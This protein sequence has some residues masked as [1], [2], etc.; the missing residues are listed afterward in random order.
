MRLFLSAGEVSGDVHGSGLARALGE[1]LPGVELVG[2]GSS[3]MAAAGVRILEDLVPL[4]AVGLTENLAVL[5]PASRALARAR[6][7][8]SSQRPDAV[9]LIDYQGANMQLAR[10][11]R[12][13]GIPSFYYISPQEW[14]WGLKGGPRRVARSVD[15]ILAVFEREA[16]VY[17]QAGGDVRFVGHPLLDQ[18]PDP[19]RVQ[20]LRR[21]LGFAASDMVLGLFPGSRDP[22][23]RSL[24]EPMIEAAELA[25]LR[26]PALRIVLPVASS[27][28]ADRIA[29]TVGQRSYIHRIE[30]ASGM[31]VLALCT[32]ALAASG[33]ITLE[34]AICG[35]PVVAAYR[36][37]AITALLARRLLK[38]PYVTLPNIVAA[39]GI[40][41]ELLQGEASPLAMAAA[42]E[43]L[44]REGPP[45]QSQLEGLAAV[46]A[47]LGES[48]AAERAA[49]AIAQ[50]LES[51]GAPGRHGR[52]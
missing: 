31:E 2:W 38:I 29:A 33:T 8:L 28:F 15:T 48:G 27:H 32:A 16:E 25:R 42:I 41:P 37:S 20:D 30:D 39:R 13:L 23:I 4:A 35:T 43:P 36:V 51:L 11:A 50:A 19:A 3:R 21:R 12:R 5:R 10:T 45:R 17:R 1:R 40:I 9:V 26:N 14:I 24:L 7:Y 52:L 46:R 47:Q 6:A 44:L 34:A 22:E 49:E 18:V